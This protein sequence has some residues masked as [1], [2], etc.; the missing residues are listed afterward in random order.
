MRRH[1]QL[2]KRK[3]QP[4]QMVRAKAATVQL[5]DDWFDNCLQPALTAL[6]LTEKPQCIFNVDETGFSLSGRPNHVLVKRGSKSVHSVIGGSGR[7]QITVQPCISGTGKLLPPYIVYTGKYL[8]HQHTDGGPLGTRFAVSTNGWM[9]TNGFIDWFKNIF[10]P[11]LPDERP[12]ILVLD[13]HSS[14]ISYQIRKIAVE[15]NITILKLPSHLT[16]MHT[17]TVGRQRI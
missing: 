10:V 9:D 15:N 16:H 4:L 13:G 14:H 3:P 8:M 5:I 12:I 6:N 11:S 7:D 1:P 2:V 17:P